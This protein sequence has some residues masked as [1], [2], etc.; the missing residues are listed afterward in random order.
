MQLFPQRARRDRNVL[1]V[2]LVLSLLLHVIG[3]G[4]WLLFAPRVATVLAKLVPRPTPAPEFVA[5]SDA[6]TIEKRTVPR[7]MRRSPAQPQHAQ[8]RP[9]RI[10][11]QPA[12]PHAALPPATLPTLPPPAAG[13][14]T[15]EP[16]AAPTYPPRHAT[17]HHPRAGAS[18]APPRLVAQHAP[19]SAA[20]SAYSPEQIAALDAQFSKTIAQAQRSLT[21]VPRQSRRPATTM[22]RYQLVMAGSRGDLTSAQGQCRAT[23]TWYRGPVVWHYMDCDFIYTDGFSEHVLIPWPQQFARNDDPSDHP[24]K[25]YPVEEPP[26]GW[27]LPHPFA[28]SRLVCI[29]YKSDCQALIERERANGDPNYAP[30]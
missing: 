20:R 5:T 7:A 1:T 18:A 10:A 22:K 23:Q 29:F 6:I 15:T 14:P 19:R 4:A 27:Q 16:T 28:F 25:L 30:P 8:P 12:V 26:A 24:Y 11:Q 17:I 13:Q 9:R 2:A 21:D 3:A